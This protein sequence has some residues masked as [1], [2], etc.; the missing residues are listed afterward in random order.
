MGDGRGWLT[1]RAAVCRSFDAPPVLEE[2]EL[3]RPAPGEVLVRVAACAVCGSDLTF[4][5]GGWGGSL[6]AVFG[7]EAAG[8]VEEVGD[9]VE[10]LR[11]GQAVVVTLVRNCG[12]CPACVRGEPALCDAPPEPAGGTPLRT[13]RG[14][15]VVQGLRT[16][17]FAERV[18][19]HASQVV[20]V[21][22]RLEM[23]AASLL[24]CGVLT[25]LGAVTRTARLGPGTTVVVVGAGGVGLNCVQGA[26][27]AG[28]RTILAVDPVATKRTA[29]ERLG[30]TG[31]LD[32]AAV[33]LVA[34]VRALTEGRGADAVFVT[35]G[36]ASVIEASVPLT[37]RGGT[38]VLVGMPSSGAF[39]SLDAVSIVDDGLAVL[40]SKMG[41]SLPSRDVPEA[42]ALALAGEL[43]LDALISSRYPLERIGEAI[44]AARGGSELR[45]VV[46]P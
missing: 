28:A 26:A 30:A 8:F 22:A 25:G 2:L 15:P 42:A 13:D 5:A 29:A 33:D 23:D 18:T 11:P 44:E 34:S 12:S 27:I 14:E 16:G 37:R 35:V 31:T 17:A 32:P 6:P 45:V 4:L 46:V 10:G 24:A 41:S 1:V 36:S 40:G 9:S 43:Q 38:V 7:H 39:V 20:P 19:V 21:D 3:R